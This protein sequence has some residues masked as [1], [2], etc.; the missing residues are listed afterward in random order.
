M[1]DKLVDEVLASLSDLA[2]AN[3]DD[4]ARLRPYVDAMVNRMR[5]GFREG[6]IRALFDLPPEPE[7]G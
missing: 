3:G 6:A 1:G 5:R 2:F 7:Q 4:L